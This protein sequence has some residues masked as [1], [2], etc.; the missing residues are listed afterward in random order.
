[1]QVSLLNLPNINM[2]KKTSNCLRQSLFIP[3]IIM[4]LYKLLI[5]VVYFL[6][7]GFLSEWGYQMNIYIVLIKTNWFLKKIVMQQNQKIK[8][9]RVSQNCKFKKSFVNIIALLKIHT[10]PI[11]RFKRDGYT[12]D[13][14][15]T[16]KINLPPHRLVWRT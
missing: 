12:V 7:S 3:C 4:I 8:F 6:F 15:N 10:I 1:M 14:V 11:I 5:F 13:I 9:F 2:F 16:T